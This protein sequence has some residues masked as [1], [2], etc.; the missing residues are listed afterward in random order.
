MQ[1]L[2]NLPVTYEGNALSDFGIA[3]LDPYFDAYNLNWVGLLTFGFVVTKLQWF[4]D[5]DC[6]PSVWVADESDIL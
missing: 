1:F 5:E 2:F 4:D 6:Y 3:T